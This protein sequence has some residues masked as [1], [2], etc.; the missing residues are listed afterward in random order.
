MCTNATD[1]CEGPN[2]LRMG[3]MVTVVF[4]SD[5]GIKNPSE[6]KAGGYKTG[7]DLLR[8]HGRR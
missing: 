1:E 4:E 2:G 5:S 6:V 8:P 3:Q 7:Y